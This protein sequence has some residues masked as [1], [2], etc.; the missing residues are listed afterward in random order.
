MKTPTFFVLVSVLV[1]FFALQ[2]GA[3]GQTT[4]PTPVPLSTPPASF[5]PVLPSSK[6]L[7]PTTALVG[8]ETVTVFEIT[9]D[10]SSNSSV[11]YDYVVAWGM[12]ALLIVPVVITLIYCFHLARRADRS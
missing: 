8:N 2:R 7:T 11:S 12:S 5:E 6:T 4:T 10:T 3:Q 9:S 1:V